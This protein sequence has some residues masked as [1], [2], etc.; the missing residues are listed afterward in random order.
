MVW[1]R[2]QEHH[3]RLWAFLGRRL[4]PGEYLGLHL[5]LG[6]LLSM[7]AAWIFAIIAQGMVQGRGLT[8][9]DQVIATDLHAFALA[10]PMTTTM[11]RFITEMGS[12]RTQSMLALVVALLLVGRRRYRLA[13]IWLIALAGGGLLDAWLKGMFQRE[14]PSFEVSLVYEPT[15]SFPS[16]HSMGSIVTYGM[17]AY[18]LVLRI[19]H[20]WLRVAVVSFL[21]VLVLGIG[22]SRIYL[23]AHWFSDVLG[24][25]AAGG[26]WLGCCISGMETLRRR[27]LHR[28]RL[29]QA[30]IGMEPNLAHEPST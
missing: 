21:S 18:L 16:G 26:V 17:L 22:F 2:I 27:R 15:L 7:A 10:S 19:P 23:G 12:F 24:G 5:T 28:Q 29:T 30:A 6:L 25:F 11:V 3:P 20:R 13:L 1:R 9:L 8:P 4:S 14:R